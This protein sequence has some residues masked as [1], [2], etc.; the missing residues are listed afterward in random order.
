MDTD[1]A[2]NN[3]HSHH[4]YPKGSNDAE[5]KRR[6]SFHLVDENETKKFVKGVNNRVKNS[7]LVRDDSELKSNNKKLSFLPADD[8]EEEEESDSQMKPTQDDDAS[9]TSNCS[10]EDH[11]NSGHNSEEDLD[12]DEDSITN[13]PTR[14]TSDI[15][16]DQNFPST[17]KE[18]TV[19]Y[20]QNKESNGSV[21]SGS[22]ES[23]NNIT[24]DTPELENKRSPSST[25]KI[26][27]VINFNRDEDENDNFD[28]TIEGKTSD[29]KHHK[30]YGS[31]LK[32]FFKDACYFQI[33]SINHENVDLSKSLGVWSTQPQNESRLC[34]AFREHRNVILIFSV[35]QSGAFQGFARMISESKPSTKP[36]PWI[37]PER[38]NNKSL[39]GVIKVDWLCTKDLPFHETQDLYNPFND[40]KPVKVARDGQ[41]V[42]PS[43]GKKL[44]KLFPHDSRK[45]LVSA[46]SRIKRRQDNEK[47]SSLSKHSYYPMTDLRGAYTNQRFDEPLPYG[48]HYPPYINMQA[49]S[50]HHPFSPQEYFQMNHNPYPPHADR[51][52]PIFGHSHGI[53]HRHQM[54]F[55]PFGPPRAYEIP[56]GLSEPRYFPPESLGFHHGP[57]F[58]SSQHYANY[59]SSRNAHRHHPYS[60][61]RR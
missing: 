1:K 30:S 52:R 61:P 2:N 55:N 10:C 41:Q 3:N 37:L 6:S 16:S 4:G 25:K 31:L 36:I 44:C 19:E 57:P 14:R 27:S 46:I 26:K 42:E 60:R 8:E 59:H 34:S 17:S 58:E 18:S 28:E 20:S 12:Y 48:H 50:N 29:D 7:N 9:S 43:V 47:K 5:F 38:L 22:I 45:Q 49:M 53:V 24:K 35:Q 33:K 51:R 23:D 13:S 54:F 39:G 56:P 21:E 32:S 40:N 11:T 15:D